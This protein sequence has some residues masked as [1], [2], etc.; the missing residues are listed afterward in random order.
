MIKQLVFKKKEFKGVVLAKEFTA[1]ILVEGTDIK[2]EPIVTLNSNNGLPYVKDFYARWGKPAGKEES[3][4][5][6]L[7]TVR[8]EDTIVESNNNSLKGSLSVNIYVQ[9]A[10]NYIINWK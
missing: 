5:V 6:V 1:D 2:G 4:N 9:G 8:F 3:S 10:N 7:L